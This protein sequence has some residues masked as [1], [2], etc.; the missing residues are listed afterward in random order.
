MWG[1]KI[2]NYKNYSNWSTNKI[3]SFLVPTPFTFGGGS[4][5]EYQIKESYRRQQ[6]LDKAKGNSFRRRRRETEQVQTVQMAFRTGG[7]DAGGLLLYVASQADFTVI[8]VTFKYI[9]M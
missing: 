3:F 9:L 1:K 7:A 6:Q 4:Y 2:L 5:V 8:Q